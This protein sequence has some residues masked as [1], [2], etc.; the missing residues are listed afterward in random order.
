MSGN[1]HV[2][3][4]GGS[5]DRPM[6]NAEMEMTKDAGG[7][8]GWWV[9]GICLC[10]CTLGLSF[11]PAVMKSRSVAKHAERGDYD[12]A[13][14]GFQQDFQNV[15][16]DSPHGAH[17]C[18]NICEHLSV[19]CGDYDEAVRGFQQDFQNVSGD[20][21]HPYPTVPANSPAMH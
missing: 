7:M 2:S 1:V 14:R 5:Y 16:G 19:S 17:F 18:T 20:S 4:P 21:P 8:M 10:P 6:T 12:E 9:F 13:V 3:G 11:I 15:S